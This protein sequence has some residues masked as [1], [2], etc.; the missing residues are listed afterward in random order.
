MTM[1]GPLIISYRRK[2][3]NPGNGAEL[4]KLANIGSSSLRVFH[5][6]LKTGLIL[7]FSYNV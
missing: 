1:D 4:S 5:G 7:C 6:A 3:K 2:L